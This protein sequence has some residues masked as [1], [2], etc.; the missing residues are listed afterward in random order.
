MMLRLLRLI[1][2]VL[3]LSTSAYAEELLHPSEAFKPAVRALDG[4]TIELRFE[5]AKGYYLYREKFRFSAEPTMPR[6]PAT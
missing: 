5:I 1:F 2:V 4:Q 6:C 3:L